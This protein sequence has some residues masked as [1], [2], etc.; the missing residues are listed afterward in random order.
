[1]PSIDKS[2][3]GEC[4]GSAA[5]KTIDI[6]ASRKIM[7]GMHLVDPFGETGLDTNKFV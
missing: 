2:P 3:I 4:N 6:G 5:V 1:M 7:V